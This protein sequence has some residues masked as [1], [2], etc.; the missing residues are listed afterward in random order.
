MR[1]M[2]VPLNEASTATKAMK[3]I[4]VCWSLEVVVN[5]RGQAC[6]QISYAMHARPMT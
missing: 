4:V 1:G 5:A 2:G 6:R 3:K